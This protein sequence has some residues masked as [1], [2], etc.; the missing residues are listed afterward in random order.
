MAS[1]THTLLL[2]SDIELSKKRVQKKNYGSAVLTKIMK[3]T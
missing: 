1:K 3:N 2:G